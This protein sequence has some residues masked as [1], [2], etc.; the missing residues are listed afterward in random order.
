MVLDAVA[1][2]YLS[3]AVI[4]VDGEGDGDSALGHEKALAEVLVDVEVIG[5]D[6]KLFAS[7][8]EGR[9]LVDVH[10]GGRFIEIEGRM[11]KWR[12]KFSFVVQTRRNRRPPENLNR[13]SRNTIYEKP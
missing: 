3:G 13:R 10:Q 4:H 2:E 1:I 9:I 6:A 12:G 11:L 7:H 5:D 8:V